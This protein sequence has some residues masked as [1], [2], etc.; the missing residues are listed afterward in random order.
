MTLSHEE[1]KTKL[2]KIIAEQLN[3]DKNSINPHSTL[4]AL[5]ADSLDQ[6]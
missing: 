2:L 1:I 4:D 5:G 3:I 6:S